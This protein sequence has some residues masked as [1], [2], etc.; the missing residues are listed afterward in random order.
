MFVV[1]VVCCATDRS[2]IQR[3]PTGR[4]LCP[5][6]CDLESSTLRLNRP[7]LGCCGTEE[8]EEET[9]GFFS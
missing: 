4:I 9:A 6:V 8:Q 1:F 3:S 2:L 5:I 7:E